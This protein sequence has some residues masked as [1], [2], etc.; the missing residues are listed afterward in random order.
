[1]K[2]EYLGDSYDFVKLSLLRCLRVLGPWSV[3]PMFTKA[4]DAERASELESFLKT[5]VIATE[6]LTTQNRTSYFENAAV[7]RHLFIDPNTG[8]RLSKMTGKRTLNYLLV[9]DLLL[10]SKDREKY[11]TMVFD[12]SLRRANDTERRLEVREKLR[13]LNEEGLY[14]FAYYSHACFLILSR[15]QTVSSDAKECLDQGL[16][17]PGSRLVETPGNQV[18]NLQLLQRD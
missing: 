2:L 4:D 1:M 14:G 6:F 9:S 15:D 3:V 8:L 12:Q 7:D 17:L 10:L 16:G 5:T 11:L 18:N 13:K